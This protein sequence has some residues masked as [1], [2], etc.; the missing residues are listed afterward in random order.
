MEETEKP[1]EKSRRGRKRLPP[2][3]KR[4]ESIEIALTVGEKERIEQAADRQGIP[5]SEWGR[6]RLLASAAKG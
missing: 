2:G 3:R 1:V 4:A 5:V 6:R